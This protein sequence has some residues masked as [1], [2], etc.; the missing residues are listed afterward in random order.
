M[1]LKG[2]RLWDMGKFDSTCR[3]P[4]R[5][6]EEGLGETGGVGG[7]AGTQYVALQVEFERR[8]LKP[9]FHFIGYRLLV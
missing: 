5:L 1:G 7:G 4:P 3:A 9:A 8:I 2:Y 6:E